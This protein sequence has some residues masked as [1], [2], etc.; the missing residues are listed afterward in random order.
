MTK[1]YASNEG[2]EKIDAGLE[3]VV[4]LRPRVFRDARGQFFESYHGAKFAGLG[5]HDQF[6]QDNQSQSMRGTLRG[7]HYQ[8]KHPQAK[9]CRAVQGEVLDV[10]VDIRLG[11][12]NFGKWTGVVLSAENRLQIYIPAGFAHGFLALSE[13][14]EF[15]YKCSDFY[16]RDDEHGIRWNDPTLGIQWNEASPLLSAKDS[17]LPLLAELPAEFLPRYE[18]D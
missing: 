2:F 18:A 12:P 10:A 7:L 3:G 9:L 17:A 5:I 11:S 14:A 8:L 15:L 13:S 4:L 1:P 6:V 16:D